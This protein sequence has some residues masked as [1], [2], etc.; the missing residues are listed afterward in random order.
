MKSLSIFLGL[1]GDKTVA[2]CSNCDPGTH[3]GVLLAGPEKFVNF[4]ELHLG[5]QRP[6]IHAMDRI[7]KLKALLAELPESQIPFEASWK[8][9]SLGLSRRILELW[10]S[11][12]MSGWNPSVN[13]SNL[14]RRMQ[15]LLRIETQLNAAGAGLPDRINAIFEELPGSSLPDAS[16]ELINDL[17]FFPELF[18]QLIR[19]LP[20]NILITEKPATPKAKSGTDL[21]VLQRSFSKEDKSLTLQGDNSLLIL[22]FPDDMA[23]ANAIHAMQEIGKWKP[24]IVNQDHGLLHGLKLSAKRPVGYWQ[25][26]SGTGE[27]SQ[28]F[29]LATAMFRSP[30]DPRQVLA[31]LNAPAS[32]F[33]RTLARELAGLFA[34][35]PGFDHPEWQSAIDTH[36]EKIKDLPQ[37]IVKTKAINFWLQNKKKLGPVSFDVEFLKDVYSK[38]EKWSLQRA[39]TDKKSSVQLANLSVLCQRLNFTLTQEDRLISPGRLERLQSQ[40]FLE[41]PSV[42]TEAQCGSEN[43]VNEPG[44]VWTASQDIL[45]MNASWRESKTCLSMHWYKEEK[46]YF[47]NQGWEVQDEAFEAKIYAHGLKRMILSA[48][49]R[50][51]I[52]VP[53]RINGVNV[54]APFCLEELKCKINMEVITK[55]YQSGMASMPWDSDVILLAK[56][57]SISLPKAVTYLNIPKGTGSIEEESFTSLENMLQHP[58]TWYFRYKLKLRHYASVDIPEARQLRGNIADGVIRKLFTSENQ[59]TPGWN[60]EDRFQK[61]IRSTL[62]NILAEEGFPFLEVRERQMLSAYTEQLV[63]SVIS[64][65]E[66]VVSNKFSIVGS[67]VALTGKI[68]EQ[69]FKGWADLILNKENRDYIFDL[70]WSDAVN[71]YRE[72]IVTGRDL[73]LAVYRQLA[74][75]SIASGYILVNKAKVLTR[76]EPAT[77]NIFNSE[78][79]AA[80]EAVDFHT[81]IQQVQKGLAYRLHEI[82]SGKLEL[83]YAT[84]TSDLDYVKSQDREGLYSLAQDDDG[85][86]ETPWDADYDLLFGNIK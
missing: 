82:Q 85:H 13:N 80:D 68:G 69:A 9:D 56:A 63:K 67:Q 10:D 84:D 44:A 42:I 21:S 35:K 34:E 55:S 47:L 18:K 62:N 57:T 54:I 51:V 8:T 28:L 52:V 27:I 78:K 58:A 38:L 31:F 43:V 6:Q 48:K 73:Q 15:E 37:P 49:E 16:V 77:S 41:A 46:D 29:F 36:I 79:I 81:T 86:K 26:A 19:H 33:S 5:L 60:D 32:P 1:D 64:L 70:K 61:L 2:H 3:A 25:P 72:K 66:F 22:H 20:S 14:P 71:T 39:A 40:I 30:A 76:D 65:R 7:L 74:P 83:G 75:N 59:N 45:W 4:I 12:R 53:E 50:L 24:L 17:K 11:W 23:A